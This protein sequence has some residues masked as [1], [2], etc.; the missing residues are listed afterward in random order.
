M[1]VY[2][3]VDR[4]LEGPSL[5]KFHSADETLR[6][7]LSNDQPMTMQTVTSRRDISNNI[8]LSKMYVN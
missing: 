2:V 6:C 8:F 7:R 1:Y 4:C 3:D 5:V